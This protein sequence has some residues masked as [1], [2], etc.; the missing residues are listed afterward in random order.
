MQTLSIKK[1][2]CTHLFVASQ[3]FGAFSRSLYKIA[4]NLLDFGSPITKF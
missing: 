1:I 2:A 3:N 4:C